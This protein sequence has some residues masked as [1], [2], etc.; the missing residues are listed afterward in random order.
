VT[1]PLAKN[2]WYDKRRAVLDQAKLAQKMTRAEQII[3]SNELLLDAENT[4]WEWVKIT[5]F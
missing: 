5:K 1:I 2:L 3:L 4:Y